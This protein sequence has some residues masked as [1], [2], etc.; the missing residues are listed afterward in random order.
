MSNSHRKITPATLVVSFL[1][2]TLLTACGGRD[3]SPARDSGTELDAYTEAQKAT[4][5]QLKQV[6]E[7]TDHLAAKDLKYLNAQIG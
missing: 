7:A 2:A 4:L 5:A 6:T 1:A 3:R